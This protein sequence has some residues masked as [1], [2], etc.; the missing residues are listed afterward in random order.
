MSEPPGRPKASAGPSWRDSA[1]RGSANE[2]PGDRAER[3][4]ET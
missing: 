1:Q 3:Q 2:P 4:G